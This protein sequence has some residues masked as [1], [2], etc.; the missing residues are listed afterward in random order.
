MHIERA[1]SDVAGWTCSTGALTAIEVPDRCSIIRNTLSLADEWG[2][3]V[4]AQHSSGYRRSLSEMMV[5]DADT[6]I[7]PTGRLRSGGA[8]RR[9][10]ERPG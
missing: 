9:R 8:S 2:P 7:A 1:A 5:I 6:H 3:A 4:P 10:M